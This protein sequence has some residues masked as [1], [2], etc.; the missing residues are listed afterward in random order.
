MRAIFFKVG[1]NMIVKVMRY[2]R[3]DETFYIVEYES[4]KCK[5]FREITTPIVKFTA[6]IAPTMR[7]YNNGT[8]KITTWE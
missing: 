3:P 1:D 4:G 5:R 6:G 7:T 2:N 8:L